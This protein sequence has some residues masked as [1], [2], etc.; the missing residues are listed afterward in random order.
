[1]SMASFTFGLL[2]LAELELELYDEL[3]LCPDPNDFFILH[4]PLHV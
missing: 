4:A 1:M 2:S 3:E